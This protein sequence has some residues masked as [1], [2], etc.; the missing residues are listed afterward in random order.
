MPEKE[1]ERKTGNTSDANNVL[2]GAVPAARTLAF[3]ADAMRRHANPS[4]GGMT[5]AVPLP[6]A[7]YSTAALCLSALIVGF[8]AFGS[9]TTTET[10]EAVIQTSAGVFELRGEGEG[11][12]AKLHVREGDR[13][14]A[15]DPLVDL[16]K[17]ENKPAG[18]EDVPQGDAPGRDADSVQAGDASSHREIGEAS[19]NA[20][21]RPGAH[22]LREATAG[23]SPASTEPRP[24]QDVVT[25]TSPMDAIVYQLPMD[26]GNNYN[27]Y[28]AVVKLAGDGDLVVSTLVSAEAH[29]LLHP[30]DPVELRLQAFKGT[31]QARLQGHVASIA[32][33]P[34]EL[35]VRKEMKT[36]FKYK[37]TISVDPASKSGRSDA[38][39]G[40]QLEIRLPVRKRRM[41]QWLFDPLKTLFGGD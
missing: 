9:Y 21:E 23:A 26:A 36:E 1:M 17:I 34:T 37:V 30:R 22:R 41:Y 29:A 27:P 40:E 28:A 20:D 16:R 33:T 11:I 32:M 7:W 24:G 13:V 12:V 10:S 31:P 25:L 6:F 8:L 5:L 19:A 35:F 18:G 2:S 39:L 14:R 4:D 38:L 3:R 15:G